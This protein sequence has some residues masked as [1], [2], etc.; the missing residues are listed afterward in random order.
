MF[1]TLSRADGFTNPFGRDDT[2][3]TGTIT[4]TF[5]T[6]NLRAL[7]PLSDRSEL[8]LDAFSSTPQN[9]ENPFIPADVP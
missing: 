2:F 6:D 7:R 9:P 3:T 5:T 8:R 1:Q 4:D